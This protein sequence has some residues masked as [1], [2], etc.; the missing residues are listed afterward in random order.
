M[1]KKTVSW[2]MT[3]NCIVTIEN[4]GKGPKIVK[5]MARDIYGDSTLLNLGDVDCHSEERAI[6]AACVFDDET[7]K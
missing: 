6:A 4:T 2:N 1:D 5:V 3:V 7:L